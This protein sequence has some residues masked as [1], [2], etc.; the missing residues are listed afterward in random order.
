LL[1]LRPNMKKTTIFL[2][3]SLVLMLISCKSEF[4]KIRTSGDVTKILT[5]ANDYYAAEK[6]QKAQTLYE[7]ILPSL[8]GSAASEQVYYK[9]AWTQFHLNNYILGQ[10]YFDNFANTFANSPNREECA[11]MAAKCHYFLSP[12]YRLE[13]GYT[14]KAMDDFQTFVNT[15]PTSTRVPECNKLMDELRRKQE[16]KAFE[17]GDLYYKMRQYQSALLAFDN[18][19]KDFPESPDVE[20]TRYLVAKSAFSLAENSVVAKK[21]ERYDLAV[22]KS[23]EFLAKFANSKFAKEISQIQESSNQQLKSIG[24]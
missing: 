18:L 14:T 12:T 24:K 19:L 20:Q 1:I 23:Q 11:F 16:K 15:F 2:A 7:I 3:F 22:K 8:K 9:Y 21:Q 17:E 6:W 4:E 10:Y 13:Q 5:R